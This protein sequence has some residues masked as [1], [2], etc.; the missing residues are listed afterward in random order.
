MH[1]LARN[2]SKARDRKKAIWA[3]AMLEFSDHKFELAD[4]LR[5]PT[6]GRP[7][8]GRPRLPVGS[9]LKR[10]SSMSRS[11]STATIKVNEY[12]ARSCQLELIL[13]FDN[14]ILCIS[15][16]TTPKKVLSRF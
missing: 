10:S 3:A 9:S 6:L 5:R 4:Q 14:L 15:E 8:L 12:E 7:R 13:A 11:S 16:T 1:I 2:P